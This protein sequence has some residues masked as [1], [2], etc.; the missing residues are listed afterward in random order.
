MQ[1]DFAAARQHLE[2]AQDSLS[3]SDETSLKVREALDLL[4][5][6]VAAAECRRPPAEIIP[7]PRRAQS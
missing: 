1:S 3:G 2:S 4:I 6:A 7:F 5:E